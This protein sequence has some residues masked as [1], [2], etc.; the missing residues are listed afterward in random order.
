M[1]RTLPLILLLVSIIACKDTTEN[2][3]RINPYDLQVINYFED[4]ALG[5]TNGNITEVTRKWAV[6][7]NVYMGGT[8]NDSL[9]QELIKVVAEINQLVTDGFSI[10]VTND[11]L[12][13]NFY[14]LLGTP[15][16]YYTLYPSL[17]DTTSTSFG[18]YYVYWQNSNDIIYGNMFVDLNKASSPSSTYLLRKLFTSALGLTNQSY[19]YPR[20]IFFSEWRVTNSYLPIDKELIRLLYH[21]DINSGWS[22]EVLRDK[23]LTILINEK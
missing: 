13:S 9:K 6:P 15:K 12:T 7:M 2:F 21:P 3:V 14:I 17:G 20:S 10:E 5:F 23:L 11:S 4:I 16:Q 8:P 1:K 22:A 19:Q 18:N